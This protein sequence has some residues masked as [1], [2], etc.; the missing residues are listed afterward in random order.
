MPGGSGTLAVGL[1]DTGTMTAGG[2]MPGGRVG[3]A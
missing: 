2:A 1:L 3:A